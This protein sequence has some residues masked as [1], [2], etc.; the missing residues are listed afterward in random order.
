MFYI[1]LS[2]QY[3]MLCLHSWHDIITLPLP[4][5]LIKKSHSNELTPGSYNDN[6]ICLHALMI[7]VNL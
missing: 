4:A 5:C 7:T 1:C 3:F 2:P 6:V